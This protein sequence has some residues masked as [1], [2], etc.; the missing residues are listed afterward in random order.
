LPF[1]FGTFDRD[2]WGEFLGADAG[3]RRL[4][5]IMRTA[6]AGFARDGAPRVDCGWE[7]WDMV[8]RT[9]L[10]L[11]DPLTCVEDP[12]ADRRAVWAPLARANEKGTR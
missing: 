10:V 5:A 1:T 6:W 9:T 3:A 2:G 12:L 11:D 4:S 7:P 8:R